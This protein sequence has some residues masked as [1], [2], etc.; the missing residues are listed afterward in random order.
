MFIGFCCVLSLVDEISQNYHHSTENIK[1]LST[2]LDHRDFGAKKMNSEGNNMHFFTCHT[3]YSNYRRVHKAQQRR[4]LYDNLLRK[5]HADLQWRLIDRLHLPASMSVESSL[6]SVHML[7]QLWWPRKRG[8]K[9]S[10]SDSARCWL[11][12]AV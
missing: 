8:E 6:W 1:M 4:F 3:I 10:I 7:V 2:T 5:V 11:A 9:K 12:E